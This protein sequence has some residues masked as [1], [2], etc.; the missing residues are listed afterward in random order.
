MLMLHLNY[1]EALLSN[2]QADGQFALF[3]GHNGMH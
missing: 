2:R 3:F 1:L